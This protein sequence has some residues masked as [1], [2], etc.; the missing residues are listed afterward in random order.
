MSF[1]KQFLRLIG[2]GAALLPAGRSEVLVRWT[3]T[4]LPP[5]QTLGVTEL[6]IPW[7][8]DGKKLLEAARKQGYRVYVETRGDSLVAVAEAV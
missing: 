6:V 8:E 2:L 7:N 5:A 1:G 3:A 4:E